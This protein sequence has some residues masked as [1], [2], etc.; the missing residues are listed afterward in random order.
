M[1]LRCTWTYLCGAEDVGDFCLSG[2]TKCFQ[3]MEDFKGCSTFHP[4]HS[5]SW[6][7]RDWSNQWSG[8]PPSPESITLSGRRPLSWHWY[9]IHDQFQRLTE[10]TRCFEFSCTEIT[11]GIRR[12]LLM[13]L[14]E[15][16]VLIAVGNFKEILGLEIHSGKRRQ[17][18]NTAC[19]IL[20]CGCSS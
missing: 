15:A 2:S 17:G 12:K 13:H 8:R 4:A 20:T 19:W 14:F 5:E 16:F 9:Q 18:G 11:S 6:C 7:F 10:L 3:W 1:K